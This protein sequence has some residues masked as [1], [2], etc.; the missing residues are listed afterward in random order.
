MSESVIF[1][2]GSTGYVGSQFLIILGRA[3]PHL[4]VRVLVRSLTVQD[5]CEFK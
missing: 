3:L 2:L 1:L 5:A 4:P